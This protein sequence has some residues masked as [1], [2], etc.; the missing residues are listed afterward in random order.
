MGNV[1][2]VFLCGKGTRKLSPKWSFV[3]S[4]I[5]WITQWL[6]VSVQ[7]W[8]LQRCSIIAHIMKE[9]FF[10]INAMF[11]TARHPFHPLFYVV[12]HIHRPKKV[13]G[14]LWPL[15]LRL[16][17][18]WSVS[19]RALTNAVNFVLKNMSRIVNFGYWQWVWKHLIIHIHLF[20]N[21]LC[22]N[23]LLKKIV[24]SISLPIRSKYSSYNKTC[25]C[26]NVC[27]TER[28]PMQTGLS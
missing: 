28:W 9:I 11:V 20:K 1:I 6:F 8:V 15:V 17:F 2:F 18:W 27:H 4:I 16:L 13:L 10:S 5:I 24:F 7:I 3:K 12:T 25:T 26:C 14:Q 19:P 22:C 23:T 21:I